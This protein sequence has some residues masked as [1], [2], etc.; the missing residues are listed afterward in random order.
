MSVETGGNSPWSDLTRKS[1]FSLLLLSRSPL[2]PLLSEQT[3]STSSV[4]IRQ[5]GLLMRQTKKFS[6]LGCGIY[7]GGRPLARR[8]HAERGKAVRRELST[9]HR[10]RHTLLT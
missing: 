2:I 3:V 6:V 9:G 7:G 8:A 10:L 5:G 1:F 4:R